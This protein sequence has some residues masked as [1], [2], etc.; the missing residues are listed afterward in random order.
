[1]DQ[2]AVVACESS[3]PPCF[4]RSRGR[5]ELIEESICFV[6]LAETNRAACRARQAASIFSRRSRGR[7]TNRQSEDFDNERHKERQ[8]DIASIIVAIILFIWLIS[9]VAIIAPII[10]AMLGSP[11]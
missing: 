6:R 1:M 3:G 10:V 4:D 7:Q 2:A 8:T 5:N 9:T 11:L